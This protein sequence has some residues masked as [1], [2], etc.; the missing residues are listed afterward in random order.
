MDKKILRVSFAYIDKLFL[1]LF[2]G[3]FSQ[4][5]AKMVSNLIALEIN[6]LLLILKR[7]LSCDNVIILPCA[8]RMT[9]FLSREGKCINVF[10]AAISAI[11]SA[12]VKRC[13]FEGKP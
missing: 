10:K 4:L 11:L 8:N 5:N 6:L 7:D 9:S 1:G 13:L 3:A 12:V 2:E